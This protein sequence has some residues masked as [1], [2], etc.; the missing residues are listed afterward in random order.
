MEETGMN[1][2]SVANETIRICEEAKYEVNGQT[3]IFPE[4]KYNEAEVITPQMGEDL[5]KTETVIPEGA[6]MC[7]I[8]IKNS[9]SYAAA[10]DH[11]KALVMNFANAHNPGGG[12][13]LGATAQEEALCR[14]STLYSSITSKEASE[15][16]KYNN[17]HVSSVESDH[18]LISPEVLVF[19]D[20]KL[21]LLEQP[22]KTAPAPNRYGAAM[23]ASGE[24][25]KETFER[26]IR[27]ILKAAAERGYRYPVLGAWGCGAFG[28][29]PD[30]VAEYF[31]KAIIDEKLGYFFDEICFAIYGNENGKNI[32]AFRDVFGER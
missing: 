17:T 23:L 16:Y 27:I 1:L 13:R 3:V 7:R 20:E 12:F 30:Q 9:D 11:D 31:R 5:L 2:I 28:N 32:T 29:K 21:D 14:C 22:F 4:G 26:R 25:I 8:V 24:K 6:A 19:R 15:M 10:R 18:M